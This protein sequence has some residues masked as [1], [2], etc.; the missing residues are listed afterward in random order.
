[1]FLGLKLDSLF[2]CR[3]RRN[4]FKD[5]LLKFT[6]SSAEKKVN[7][8]IFYGYFAKYYFWWKKSFASKSLSFRE[9]FEHIEPCHFQLSLHKTLCKI[10]FKHTIVGDSKNYT[11]Q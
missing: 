6:K 4:F 2:M 1:M 9:F 7:I 8:Y 11:R 5:F 3:E 10:Y